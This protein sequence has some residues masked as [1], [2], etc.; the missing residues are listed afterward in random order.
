MG[1]VGIGRRGQVARIEAIA[2]IVA[3]AAR[4]VTIGVRAAVAKVAGDPKDGMKAARVAAADDPS[5]DSL[6]SSWRN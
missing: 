1:L 3:K 4:A 6:R 2:V 5:K